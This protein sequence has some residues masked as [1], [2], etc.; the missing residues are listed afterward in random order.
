MILLAGI[1]ITWA[2]VTAD[3]NGTPYG[4]VPVV[5]QLYG[6]PCGSVLAPLGVYKTGK[7]VRD[8]KGCREYKLT[9]V[10]MS[11]ESVLWESTPSP[12][13]TITVDPPKPGV[14]PPPA[15]VKIAL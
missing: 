6:G 15:D 4:P 12:I 2:L 3:I 9:S 11:G 10:I 7:A 5:Y 13:V 1:T 8:D 14:P